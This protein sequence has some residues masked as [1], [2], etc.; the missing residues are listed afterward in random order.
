MKWFVR[1]T[2]F[3]HS[4]IIVYFCRFNSYS[5]ALSFYFSMLDKP[6]AWDLEFPK[7]E[8]LRCVPCGIELSEEDVFFDE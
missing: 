5:S 7:P 8:F 2:E 4:E 1:W 3:T 6:S